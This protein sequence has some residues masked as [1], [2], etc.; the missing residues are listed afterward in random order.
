MRFLFSVILTAGLTWGLEQFFP[1]YSAAAAAFI[2]GYLMNI[3]GFAALLA[4]ALG[5]G[6]LWLSFAWIIDFQ[7]SSILTEK[8]TKLMGLDEAMY[9]IMITLAI[10]ALVGGLAAWCGQSLRM[11]MV[12]KK[13]RKEQYHF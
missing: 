7:T 13:K 1:W 8:M 4:G 12:V 9:M 5:V 10:G 2:I 3:R 6:L 11:A